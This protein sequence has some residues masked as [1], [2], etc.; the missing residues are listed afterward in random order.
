M[1]TRTRVGRWLVGGLVAAG[2]PARAAAQTVA[3]GP[4]DAVQA[5][6]TT[7]TVFDDNIFGRETAASDA[8][9]RVTPGLNLTLVR[10][11]FGMA[12]G[13]SFDAERYQTHQ[14]LSSVQA[15]QS[16]T[17]AASYRASP[18]TTW[19][20]TADHSTTTNPTELNALTA[21][22]VDRQR[23][24][25]WQGGSAVRQQ[26]GQHAVFDLAYT[27]SRDALSAASVTTTHTVDAR[28]TRKPT[29]HT[30][31][32]MHAAGRHFD[33]G[34]TGI[35]PVNSTL[36]TAGW[37]MHRKSAHLTAE[38]GVEASHLTLGSTVEVSAGWRFGQ[39]DVTGGYGRGTTTAFG[40]AG[41]VAVDH[42]QGSV[43]YQGRPTVRAAA[44]HCTTGLHIG[45]RV[46]ASRNLLPTG[47][48]T[49]LQWA[50][51]LTRPISRTLSLQIGYDGST[52]RGFAGTPG[53]VV[54]DVRRNRVMFALSFFPWSPR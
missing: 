42:V 29:V 32:F 12:F 36:V 40:V 51:D 16:G 53:V 38:G 45:V 37:A 10:P 46:G 27:F 35:A 6:V 47:S 41:T 39:T 1:R 23:A 17:W 30:D 24:S 54:G 5:S 18:R 28:L 22:N 8:I 21:L 7:T 52:Q 26:A 4:R 25:R 19:S 20:W 13:I 34:K 50:A 43:I 14:D 33:F 11:H 49:G 3:A 48:S 15:R 9:L 2:L 31:F 44:G